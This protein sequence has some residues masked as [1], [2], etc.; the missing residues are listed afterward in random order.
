M[1]RRRRPT[2]SAAVGA[3]RA[4]RP[5]ADRIWLLDLDNTLHDAITHLMPGINRA[6]TEFIARE[7]DLHPERASA[8]RVRYWHRYG[9]TLLGLVH[10]HGVDPHHFLAEAHRLPDLERVVRRDFA[11]RHAL[12]R[13]RGRRIILTNAP[14]AYAHRVIEAV[15]IRR[16]VDAVIPIEAMRFAGR[17]LPKPSRAMLRKLLARLRVDPARCVLVEDSPANLRAAR[18]CGLRTI[19]VNGVG[20]ATHREALR[21][22]AGRGRYID[23]QIGQAHRLLRLSRIMSNH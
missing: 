15:G 3:A 2:A 12:V 5:R 6:M 9:A 21:H 23:H 19:L 11:L 1:I 4:A 20:P 16:Q 18:A 14:E 10:H 22:R 8:L 13:L 7:L 17:F